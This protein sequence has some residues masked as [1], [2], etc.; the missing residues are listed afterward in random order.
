MAK[1]AN[2]PAEAQAL[3][4]GFVPDLK[5]VYKDEIV[6]ALMKLPQFFK[7]QFGGGKLWKT[8]QQPLAGAGITVFGGD[9]CDAGKGFHH[10]VRV[11]RMH[12]CSVIAFQAA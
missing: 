12:G 5:K 2:K 10:F 6:P 11:Y 1:K 7:L 8:V 9:A 3:P 4:K